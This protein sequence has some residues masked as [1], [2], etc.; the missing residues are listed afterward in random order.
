MTFG[1]AAAYRAWEVLMN[2][3][4]VL[5]LAWSALDALFGGLA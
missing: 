4:F 2:I 3:A 1:D 5:L